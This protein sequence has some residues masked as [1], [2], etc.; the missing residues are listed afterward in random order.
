MMRWCVSLLL[1][2]LAN[3][4]RW[5][6]VNGTCPGTAFK[7]QTASNVEQ[8]KRRCEALP[9]CQGVSYDRQSQNCAFLA[10][11]EAVATETPRCFNQHHVEVFVMMPLDLV[12]MDGQLQED[13]LP[14]IWAAL[15]TS[16]ADG[17]MVDVWWGI[18]EPEPKKYNFAPYRRLIDEA[19]SRGFKVQIVSSFHQ[20]SGNVGDAC[21][22]PL[23]EFV[24]SLPDIWYKDAEGKETKEYIS[25]FA[26]AVPLADQRTPLKMYGDWFKAFRK[27]FKKELKGEPIVEIMVGLGPCGEMRY[28]S[29]PLDRWSFSGIGAFQS[30]DI[31]ALKSLRTAAQNET[32]MPPHVNYNDFPQDTSFFSL[33]HPSN[34][35]SSTGH[36]FLDWYSAALKQHGTDVISI[37]QK[38]F[39]K[40]RLA[41][42]IS[43]IH[44]WY[45]SPSHAA[46][47][48]AG[49]YNTNF[50][51]AYLEIAQV[52]KNAGAE[53]FD[54]TCLEMRDSEQ[55]ED[56]HSGPEELVRQ[57]QAA[58]EAA[59]LHFAGENA[60]Q[61]YDQSAYDQMLV[62]KENLF[63]LTYLRMTEALMQPENLQRF[64]CFVFAMHGDQSDCA[65]PDNRQSLLKRSAWLPEVKKMAADITSLARCKAPGLWLI[66]GLLAFVSAAA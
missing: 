7:R 9:A 5:R 39:K 24:R 38:I 60:L 61:R 64:R 11:P 28:P 65:I 48:T 31:H 27:E 29:Y 3:A 14:A 2:W 15:A 13:Q 50:H 26:D 22:I 8:C 10:G 40:V 56:A 4:D 21:N 59:G 66:F 33:N 44:W 51:N 16:K 17:F 49:Y 55:P 12:S 34:Y 58:A 54:F 23:P 25:L 30:F 46:E 6:G 1:L 42:K 20:C 52:L 45:Q 53:V 37:A 18:T 62:Y 57:S 43:G 19:K 32:F 41:A 35:V 36:F 63:A 47:V